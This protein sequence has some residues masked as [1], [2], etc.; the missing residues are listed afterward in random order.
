[1]IGQLKVVV[2]VDLASGPDVTSF[3]RFERGAVVGRLTVGLHELGEA[4]QLSRVALFGFRS[5]M[6]PRH[7]S[8]R[9]SCGSAQ[10]GDCPVCGLGG[11]GVQ[12]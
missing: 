10:I 8:A 4:F 1:M 5:A 3:T 2:G 9:C 6:L 12:S 11:L 7:A